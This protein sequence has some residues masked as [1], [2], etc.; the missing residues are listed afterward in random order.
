MIRRF[1]ALLMMTGLLLL[2]VSGCSVNTELGGTPI[3]NSRPDT[4]VTGQP[5]TLLEAGFIVQFN[6]TG[7]DVDGLIEGFQWKI[8]NN[9]LDGIS[10]RDTMTVDPL[11]GAEL[12]PWF[13]TEATDSLF[14]V[15]ADQANFPNDPPDGTARSFRTHTLWIRAVDDDGAVD[16]SP[17]QISFTSTTLVP[18]ARVQYPQIDNTAVFVPQT[19]NLGYEGEDPDFDL[20]VPTRVRFLWVPAYTLDGTAINTRTRYNY[21]YEELIN[22][23]DPDWTP[24]VPYATQ[25]DARKITYEDRPPGELFLF[26]VQVQDTAGAVSVGRG[27]GREVFNVEIDATGTRFSPGVFIGEVFLGNSQ[28]PFNFDEIAAGQPLNFSWRGDASHYNGTVTSYRHG[29]DVADMD[30]AADPGWSVPP[31]L[32]EQNRFAEE[33]SF[34]EGDHNFCLRVEDDSGN[35]KNVIWQVRIIPNVARTFQSELLLVDQVVD[36]STGAWPGQGGSPAYDLEEFRN[37]YWRFL[38]GEGGVSGFSWDEDYVGD[39]DLLTYSELVWYKAC[40]L[41]ARSHTR[42]LILDQFRAV[43]NVDKYNWL[44]PYQEQGGNLFLVG[45]RSLD[46]FLEVTGDYMV[47]IIFDTAE[48]TYVVS[49]DSYTVGFGT[50]EKPD[51][52]EVDRG[53][54]QYP[55]ATAGISALDWAVPLGKFVYGSRT[56]GSS[57]RAGTC[58]GIKALVLDE[59]F[60]ANHGLGVGAIADTIWTNPTIDWRD[61]FQAGVDTLDRPFDFGADEFV[62]ANIS[63]R[64]TPLLPQTC[65][66]GPGD[67]CIEPM[68]RG[69]A[70]F[71]WIRERRYAEGEMDWPSSRYSN[72]RLNEIC[73]GKTL[74]SYVRPDDNVLVNPGA[75]LTNG[76]TYGFM[77]Y[78]TIADKPGYKPDVYW[79]FDPY[80]FDSDETQKAVLWVLSEF[81]LLLN[82]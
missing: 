18:R 66:E 73:G 11:T 28:N 19:V 23:D 56:P 62:N 61:T 55:Y 33:N 81:G 39:A 74:T 27:Y 41:F 48:E 16:P 52:T 42:Q 34:E 35:V 53:P 1:S 26:A 50:K 3:P 2:L 17:A 78:K 49:G 76:Q 60:A 13:Y 22:F 29:W 6:W 68:F 24:W 67:Q 15:L 4:R 10:P 47:P 51:G 70:R 8:S 75:S 77:S 20:R 37:A 43:N 14:Y 31:G 80:R 54:L 5:P 58:A 12:N 21:A 9:G 65:E 59:D 25:E 64:G 30:D 7:S 69:H 46:S 45:E 36:G 57:D 63:S 71:D 79:G 72:T 40:L 32:S 38:E 44:T 82:Q